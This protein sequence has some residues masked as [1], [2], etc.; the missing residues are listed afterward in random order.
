MVA[1]VRFSVVVISAV[2]LASACSHTDVVAPTNTATPAFA[3]YGPPP[4]DG[5]VVCTAYLKCR[6][7][8]ARAGYIDYRYLCERALDIISPPL[9]SVQEDGRTLRYDV[10]C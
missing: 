9:L 2:L 7:C 5:G 8:G 6:A 4:G 1:G 10:T 3:V